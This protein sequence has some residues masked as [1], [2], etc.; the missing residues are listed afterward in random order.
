MPNGL[1]SRARPCALRPC[2]LA[3]HSAHG[4]PSSSASRRARSIERFRSVSATRALTP[5]PI[6]M[7]PPSISPNVWRMSAK[8]QF[9]VRPAVLVAG[10]EGDGYLA[11]TRGPLAAR[12]VGDGEERPPVVG[13]AIV[14][15]LR[16][17]RVGAAQSFDMIR[18]PTRG[19]AR[20]LPCRPIGAEPIHGL[21]CQSPAKAD[22][23]ASIGERVRQ[24]ADHR[25]GR[26]SKRIEMP[27]LAGRRQ[28]EGDR[29]MERRLGRIPR[30]RPS[31]G[32]PICSTTPSC[33]TTIRSAIVIAS[34]WSCVT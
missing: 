31:L 23:D 3:P 33:M 15:A 4:R 13:G 18:G 12:L 2:R 22:F 28:D 32:V 25:D 5:Y 30:A 24:S 1:R 34:I 10:A 16:D 20:E 7:T 19:H 9:A 11:R 29:T 14:K 6:L 17:R 8:T 27:R 26:R 21:V